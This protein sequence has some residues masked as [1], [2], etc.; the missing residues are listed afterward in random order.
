VRPH[1]RAWSDAAKASAD[2]VAPAIACSF[3][4]PVATQSLSLDLA[5][6]SGGARRSDA[7]ATAAV[8]A[9]H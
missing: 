6:A 9:R 5:F 4:L 3:A 1:E 2:R 7:A 8:T